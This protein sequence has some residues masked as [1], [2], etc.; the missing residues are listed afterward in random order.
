MAAGG[1]KDHEG[2]SPWHWNHRKRLLSL[3]DVA[4]CRVSKKRNANEIEQP[5]GRGIGI[6]EEA[7][8]QLLELLV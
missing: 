1:S 7:M 6:S 2:Y 4:L 8:S 5:T 3:G